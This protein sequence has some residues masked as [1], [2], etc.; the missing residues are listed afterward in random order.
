MKNPF[1]NYPLQYLAMVFEMLP[2]KEARILDL[3]CGGGRFITKLNRKSQRYGADVDGSKIKKLRK[4]YKNIS[5]SV[6]GSGGKLP[7]EDNFFDAVCLLHVLEHVPSEQKTIKEIHRVL[8]KSGKLYMASPY[9]GLFT[10][11][12]TANLRFRYPKFHKI[13]YQQ[14][15]GRINYEEK[16]AAPKQL[17]GDC[18]ESLSWH[19][20]YSEEEI[21]EL[22][23]KGFVIEKF[24]KHAFFLPFLLVLQNFSKYFL[25]E[26][27][28]LLNWVIRLDNKLPTGR[29]SYNF[30]VVAR[31]K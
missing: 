18:H 31:K 10:W 17:R 13:L 23:K 24:T 14:I 21:R 8:K 26:F 7:Y 9:N 12:D 4:K 27:S 11:A 25:G 1:Y 30:I 20:H 3:G 5:F 22:L 6:L 2:Q 15:S 28:S 16:F 19:K 29:F